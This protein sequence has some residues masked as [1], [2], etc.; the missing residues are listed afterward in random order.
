MEILGVLVSLRPEGGQ[1][2]PLTGVFEGDPG[3]KEGETL[4][5]CGE[6]FQ[7]EE[8]ARMHVSGC[9]WCSRLSRR[10]GGRDGDRAWPGGYHGDSDL[11]SEMGQEGD[12]T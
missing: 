9:G 3:R 12:S 5:G 2:R 8:T 1:G 10:P 7:A 11:G 6:A 4:R